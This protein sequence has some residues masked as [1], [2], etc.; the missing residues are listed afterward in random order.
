[1][2]QHQVLAFFERVGADHA[3]HIQQEIETMLPL[4]S[5]HSHLA[6]QNVHKFADYFAAPI[7]NWIPAI[8]SLRLIAQ[9]I[10]ETKDAIVQH[11]GP[12]LF[13]LRALG[14]D[15]QY[16][17]NLEALL[18]VLEVPPT[19]RDGSLQKVARFMALGQ[20]GIVVIGAGFSYDTMPIT[21]ELRP[22]LVQIL[23]REGVASPAQMID[24][25]VE[26]VW[27]IAKNRE[28][29]F[30]ERFAGYCAGRSYSFQHSEVAR[31]LHDGSI[32][33]LISVNW[34]DLCERAFSDAFGTPITKVNRDGVLPD[35]PALWKLHGD[36]E[37]LSEPWVFPYEEGRV[38]DSLLVSLNG[39]ADTPA[40][41][42]I[43][44][45][46]EQEP[47][48]K[49]KL[50]RWLNGNV[51]TVLRVRPNWPADDQTGVPDS[52]KHFFQRLHAYVHLEQG[53][54]S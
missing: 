26:Q 10:P 22:L 33:H 45:Y 12:D 11:C 43:I 54:Q 41:A 14:S 28:E 16:A 30:K 23:L 25:E 36:V 53:T 21:G 46:S 27:T 6:V 37:N 47:V 48:V 15:A 24:R 1:M 8:A 20:K 38:F 3:R 44:G 42:L 51:P 32:S 39:L 13:A 7:D 31:I 5:R 50:L 35:E 34:D 9:A 29:V 40:F 4:L 19:I 2:L 17:S 52:A 18:R 49:M